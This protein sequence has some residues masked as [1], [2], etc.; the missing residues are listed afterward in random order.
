MIEKAGLIACIIEDKKGTDI[1]ALDMRG[2]PSI[3]ECFMLCTG[4][5]ARHTNALAE[6]IRVEL[7]KRGKPVLRIERDEDNSWVL[8]DCGD[9]ICHIFRS[10]TREYYDLERLWGD[11]PRIGLQ[12]SE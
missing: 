8:I 7:S 6:A 5:S 10:E 3:S 9:I 1:V 12:Q 4:T 11:I 2:V